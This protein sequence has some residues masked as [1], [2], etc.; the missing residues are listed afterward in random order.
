MSRIATTQ[1]RAGADGGE[2][3]WHGRTAISAAKTSEMARLA[4]PPQS[5][6]SVEAV[7]AAHLGTTLSRG[8]NGY[9]EGPGLG[10]RASG[11]TPARLRAALRSVSHPDSAAATNA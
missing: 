8:F 3:A 9:V 1:P 2:L 11:G 6:L 10:P 5:G 7:N 4:V